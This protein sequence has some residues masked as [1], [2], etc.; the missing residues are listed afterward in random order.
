MI[1]NVG[2]VFA[3]L[4]L[5]FF[6]LLGLS[7]VISSINEFRINK[8]YLPD[9]TKGGN[10]KIKIDDGNF[11]YYRVDEVVTYVGDRGKRSVQNDV[12]QISVHKLTD[13]EI[14]DELLEVEK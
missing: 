7:F 2:Y 11:E 14:S 10:I 8:Q 9:I 13:D 6:V 4:G 12:K 5:L 3:G 1:S